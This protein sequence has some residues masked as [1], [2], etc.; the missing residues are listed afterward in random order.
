MFFFEND[1]ST[2][3]LIGVFQTKH[4]TDKRSL[5]AAIKGIDR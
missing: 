4:S 3:E 1:L 2:P 5:S